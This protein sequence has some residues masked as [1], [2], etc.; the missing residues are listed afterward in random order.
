MYS[1]GLR[2]SVVKVTVVIIW[3]RLCLWSHI[4]YVAA[5]YL[6]FVA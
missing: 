1:I 6:A 4:L 5:L 2:H 3:F